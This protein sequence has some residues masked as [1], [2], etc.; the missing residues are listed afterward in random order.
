MWHGVKGFRNSPAVRP[1]VLLKSPAGR[2]LCFLF[3]SVI[4]PTLTSGW[5]IRVNVVLEP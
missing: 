5:L 1:S 4:S 2:L 3:E